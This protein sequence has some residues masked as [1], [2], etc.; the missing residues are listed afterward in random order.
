M[1]SVNLNISQDVQAGMCGDLHG[2]SASTCRERRVIRLPVHRPGCSGRHVQGLNVYVSQN[3]S[4]FLQ[5][6]QGHALSP[7]L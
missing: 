6:L 2:C 5:A 3:I 7:S 1:T 4:G